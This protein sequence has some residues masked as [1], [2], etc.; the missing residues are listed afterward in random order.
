M[1]IPRRGG[2]E[3]PV[4][5]HVDVRG[6]P[7]LIRE[8]QAEDAPAL[9][10]ILAEL[11]PIDGFILLSPEEVVAEP[12]AHGGDVVRA[13]ASGG[14]W[15]LFVAEQDGVVAGMVDLRAVPLRRCAHVCELGIG[16][17]AG[18]RDRGIG[19]SLVEHAVQAASAHGFRKIRLMVIASN[20]RAIAVYRRASFVET[21]RFVDEVR[22]GRGFEDLVVMERMLP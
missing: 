17:R 15:L 19:R 13:N 16:V 11:A 9:G 8:A 20:T 12:V 14:R 2:P 10:S 7:F 4:G 18:F 22:L 3:V 5:L 6:A 21:G 1:T